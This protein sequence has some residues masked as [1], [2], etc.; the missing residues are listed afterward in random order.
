MTSS[1]PKAFM[2]RSI[3][4]QEQ[5]PL[6]PSEREVRSRLILTVTLQP[7]QLACLYAI[8]ATALNVP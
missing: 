5:S 1:A 2:E 7:P 4:P 6:L 8:I 3:Q